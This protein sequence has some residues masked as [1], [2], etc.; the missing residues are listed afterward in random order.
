M[1]YGVLFILPWGRYLSST[2]RD[3]AEFGNWQI[4]I[5]ILKMLME[6]AVVIIYYVAGYRLPLNEDYK[7]PESYEDECLLSRPHY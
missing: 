3:L 5:A 7:I 2:G 1:V 6:Y 4:Y